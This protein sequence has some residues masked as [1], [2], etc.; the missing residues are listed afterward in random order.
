MRERVAFPLF[1][2][3]TALIAVASVPTYEESGVR[4][5]ENPSS[6]SNSIEYFAIIIV[7][8]GFVLLMARRSPRTL[9]VVMYGLVL[10][11]IYYVLEPF[12]GILSAIPAVGLTLLL[13]KRPNWVVV[14]VS[15]L[16]LAAGITSIFGISL[17]PIPVIVLMAILAVYDFVSV[18]KTGHMLDLAESVV[19]MG[20]P[21][22]FIVPSKDK[23]MLLGVGDVVIP[24]ILVVSAQSF[25]SGPV[26]FSIKIPALTA[27]IGG[28]IGMITLM[29]IAEK[30]KR[31][32]AGLPFLN[33][34]TIIGF[35]IGMAITA[36]M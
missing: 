25:I 22:I 29:K 31:P 15:A 2:L 24:N 26:V 34:F 11:S 1:Y 13:M 19:K 36:T 23:P 5:F 35:V 14:D 32:H 33:S 10:V 8:T 9:K 7:F 3:L 16:L 6:V 28:I 21:M 18:Y 17:T 12:L 27:L 4:V 30:S 20:L